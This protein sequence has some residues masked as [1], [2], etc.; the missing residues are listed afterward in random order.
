MATPRKSPAKKA[1][2]KTA[3]T[4]TKKAAAPAKKAAA[5]QPEPP[6]AGFDLPD[7]LRLTPFESLDPRIQ[8]R[9]SGE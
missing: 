8:K 3:K 4:T 9:L 1:A 6:Y 5:K 2:A 7:H